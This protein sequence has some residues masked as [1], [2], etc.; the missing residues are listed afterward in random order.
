M[1]PL[2]TPLS[3]SLDLPSDSPSNLKE[4]IDWILRVT[5][6][7]GGGG[8]GDA[9]KLAK[10]IT[11]LPDFQQAITAAADKLKESGSVDISQALGKLKSE[12]TLK[13]IIEKLAGGL[14]DFIGYN[15]K[16]Q[17]IALVIDPLQQ[18]RKGVLMFLQMILE[19]LVRDLI[20][21]DKG[22]KSYIGKAIRNSEGVSFDD[23]IQKIKGINQSSSRHPIP[24]VLSALQN[25]EQLRKDDVKE[26]ADGLNKYLKAVFEA[27]NTD[28][29]NQ[30]NI[31]I[32]SLCSQLQTLL[33]KVGQNGDLS[34]EIN[35]VNKAEKQLTYTAYHHPAK[36][37]VDG[38][39][40]A[41]TSFLQ[42]LQKKDG[43]KSS[44]QGHNWNGITTTD[45]ISQIFLG[46]LPL[47]YYW[48]TYLYWKC[49]QD[50]DKGGWEGQWLNS[51][52][53]SAFLSG[54]GY[55]REYLKNQAGKQFAKTSFTGF[56]E[57]TN[58]VHP[59][60][61]THAEFFQKLRDTGIEKW[62]QEPSQSPSTTAQ[63]H[64]LS[65]LYIL[66][67][68]YFGH[69]QRLN[70]RESRPPTSIR[71]MLY[72]L[73]ALQFSPNYY[74]VQKQIE[75]RIPFEGLRVA[76]SSKPSTSG[77]SDRGSASAGDTLTRINFNDYL[78]L[79]CVFAPALLGTIQ[80]H[81]ADSEKEPWLH[82]LFSNSEFKLS[83]ASSGLTLF[84][85]LSQYSYALQFQL[86]FLY[87]QCVNGYNDGCGWWQCS[88]GKNVNTQDAKHYSEVSSWL[89]SSS[90]CTSGSCQ[91]NSGKCQHFKQCGQSGK[92]SPLQAFLTDKLKGFSLSKNPVPD[93]PNH[94]HNHPPGYLCHVQMGFA[95][96]LRSDLGGGA[97][98]VYALTPLFGTS[99]GPLRQL[100]EKLGCITKRTP[101]TLGDFFGFIWHLNGQLFKNT[102][103]T[104]NDLIRKFDTAFGL[105]NGLTSE[106]SNNPCMV[107]AQIWDKIA[108]IRSKSSS[109]SNPSILSL[110]LESMAPAIPFLY[111]LFMAE[112]SNFL[113][114][115]LF[116]VRG[117]TH[118]TSYH[119]THA[120]IFGLY[121]PECS[122]PNTNCGPY[123]SPLTHTTGSAFAPKHA[124]SYLSWVLYLTDDLETE[125][126]GLLDEFRNIDCLRSECLAPS[127]CS[128]G[129]GNHGSSGCTCDS[130][131]RCGSVLPMLYR[132][133]FRYNSPLELMG[134]SSDSNTKR[135][136]KAFA[137]QLQSVINGNPLASL[138]T[139]IDTFLYAI[140]WEFFSKLS[141]FWL[142]SLA[143]LLY[144]IFY[145]IDVLHLK[146]HVH[147][148]SSHDI[149]SIGLFTTGKPSVL[150]KFTKL[151]YFMP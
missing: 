116:D 23:A 48:L 113:P 54:Q 149:P 39:K 83:Y 63:T 100:S 93:S 56:G 110:S 40:V 28:G 42:P 79:T 104:L 135:D 132:H 137:D 44:Y 87:K 82:S 55:S 102:R 25:T 145:G 131:V 123:L 64:P 78:T 126:W 147:F 30:A 68:T 115:A 140:R 65:G 1:L 142:C 17:G 136:C 89:C 37:L 105:G 121:Y 38:L 146:S 77:S 125:L 27:V 118:K 19:K 141:S 73:S 62:K 150:T 58:P 5:G 33:D 2:D 112:E 57:L 134:G 67:S 43:Y 127:T 34:T 101:R 120:D 91:H 59:P 109:A 117:T 69:Q 29:K 86:S 148:P 124:S 95:D 35:D 74:E 8:D 36:S 3:A 94:F 92:S 18:L 129:A 20:V 32:N 52:S 111:Q 107:I 114:S 80:G 143:I 14:G 26:L 96:K 98:I 88:F 108:E 16:G 85:A 11:Q 75:K 81:S 24:N 60:A 61:S 76:D 151:V 7:D 47:C 90:K 9:S 70:V 46:C 15:G 22:A 71:E 50:R 66:T 49:K 53:L 13:G 106:F 139:S 119:G 130:I 4:A 128:H 12:I 72:W 99:N 10:A 41:K 138:L 122:T 97:N 144:F 84:Y 103:P 21:E 6:R 45:K 51:G 133:G 31:Q